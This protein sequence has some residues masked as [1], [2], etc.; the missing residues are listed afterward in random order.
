MFCPVSLVTGLSFFLFVTYFYC[1]AT[2]S[3]VTSNLTS[4]QTIV[5]EPGADLEVSRIN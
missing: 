4:N 2:V 1:Y 3:I 5:T